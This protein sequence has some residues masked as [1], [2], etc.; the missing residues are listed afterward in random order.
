MIATL[1]ILRNVGYSMN[2]RKEYVGA[3]LSK[4]YSVLADWNLIWSLIVATFVLDPSGFRARATPLKT[5]T[6]TFRATLDFV[7]KPWTCAHRKKVPSTSRL[8]VLTSRRRGVQH[9]SSL[10]PKF[11]T[12]LYCSH[13]SDFEIG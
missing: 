4:S 13:Y 11:C 7:T 8:R 3:I 5:I 12:N 1:L 9:S 10:S 2:R 6:P